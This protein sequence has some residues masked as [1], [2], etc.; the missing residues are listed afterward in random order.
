MASARPR[1]D[2]VDRLRGLVMV[3]MALDHVRDFYGD[4]RFDA[5]DLADPRASVP[6]F[7]TRWVTHFC[8]P[9]FIFLTGV[10]AYLAAG[11]G[12][13]PAQLAGFLLTRGLWIVFLEVALISPMWLGF[14]FTGHFTM[15]G[16]FWAIGWSM[17]ALSALVFLPWPAI[18]AIG[19]ALIVGHN[20]F[21]A[22]TPGEWGG[23]YWL[24]HVLHAPGPIVLADG[25]VFAIGYPLIPW[26]GVMAVGYVFGRVLLL[27]APRRRLSL[28]V[29]GLAVTGAF[30]AVRSWG[31][32]GDTFRPWKR[33]D[34]PTLDFLSFLNCH[35]YPPSLCYVLMT[36]GPGILLLAVFD[37]LP[38]GA[39]GR[40][41]TVFGRVPMFYYLL[42][43]PL[44]V[45]SMMLTVF[46]GHKLDLLP[47][48]EAVR[49]DGGLHVP[50]WGVYLL[51]LAAVTIL[52]FPCRW[53]AGVKQRYRSAWLSYL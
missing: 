43:L 48:L 7:L 28:V 3:L 36:L 50:L 44:I 35:K 49:R 14:N 41:L 4:L 29:I 25:Y 6:L 19:L 33:F 53:F 20:A 27:D 30:V 12:R 21:D 38:A 17:V 9:T 51:W 37:V 31:L 23:L 47:D 40:V 26:A 18:L 42:H 8:A 5:T 24:F 45:G 34:D 39:P 2:S 52:Y 22:K 10:G 32:Y 11:R 46:V 1:L 16:V 13:T 15:A